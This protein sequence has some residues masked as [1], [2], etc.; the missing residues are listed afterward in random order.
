MAKRKT[1]LTERGYNWLFQLLDASLRY[2]WAVPHTLNVICA[3][4]RDSFQK[5]GRRMFVPTEK[6]FAALLSVQD[7]LP[8][9]LV[10]V[11]EHYKQIYALVHD[12]ED[13]GE[14]EEKPKKK[15]KGKESKAKE[16]KEKP[17]GELPDVPPN[18]PYDPSYDESIGDIDPLG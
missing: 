1:I 11:V 6:Q 5:Y 3:T 14:Q 17:D 8:K 4:L 16:P 7:R 13:E 2:S 15:P 18:P 12:E 9:G 10:P